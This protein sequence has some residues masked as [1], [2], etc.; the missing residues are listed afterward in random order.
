[1]TLITSLS[2][3][4]LPDQIAWAKLNW[5]FFLALSITIALY[6]VNI[7]LWPF[8]RC[9][10]AV[11]YTRTQWVSSSAHCNHFDWII[12]VEWF[13]RKYFQWHYMRHSAID[14]CVLLEY[15]VIVNFNLNEV[16]NNCSTINKHSAVPPSRTEHQNRHWTVQLKIDSLI[17]SL[18]CAFYAWNEIQ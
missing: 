16:A 6:D 11:W 17:L 8:M 14:G 2:Q 10:L 13:V 7:W 3:C 12:I 1:M 18:L 15:L 9:R 4:L 5:S